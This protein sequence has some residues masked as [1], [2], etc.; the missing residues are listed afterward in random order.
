VGP[1]SSESR[2]GE[3]EP[4]RDRSGEHEDIEIDVLPDGTVRL[5]ARCGPGQDPAECA[6]RIRFLVEAL[7][8]SMDGVVSEIS[9][10][11][12]EDGPS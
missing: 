11:P 5:H 8:I 4:P 7:G 9:P 2:S 10:P 1:D 12:A 3:A 6:E